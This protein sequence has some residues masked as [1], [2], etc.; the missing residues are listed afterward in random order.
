MTTKKI[1]SALVAV[2]IAAMMPLSVFANYDPVTDTYSNGF[3]GAIDDWINKEEAGLTSW[4]AGRDYNSVYKSLRYANVFNTDGSGKYYYG[5]SG[6][7]SSGATY[8]FLYGGGDT[9]NTTTNS[10]TTYKVL[11]TTNNSWYNPITNNYQTINNIQYSPTYNTYHITNNEYNTY[12]TNNITYVSYYIVDPVEELSWYYEIYYMLPDG[13]NTYNLQPEDVWGQYFIYDATNYREVAE[14]DGTT[15]ALLHFDGNLQDSS[16]HN[17]NVSYSTGANYNFAQ[18]DFTGAL[19]WNDGLEHQLNITLPEN[20]DGD[21]T[22]EGRVNVL[23]PGEKVLQQCKDGIWVDAPLFRIT[24]RSF[25]D[26]EAMKSYIA[27]TYSELFDIN[28]LE[29]IKGTWYVWINSADFL[30]PLRICSLPIVS[31]GAV[32]L[33]FTSEYSLFSGNVTTLDNEPFQASTNNNNGSYTVL[34]TR[35]VD[36]NNFTKYFPPTKTISEFKVSGAYTFAVV[37]KDN[38]LHYYI[39]GLEVYTDESTGDLGNVISLNGRS[40]TVAMFD[41]LRV[42]NK[43][44]YTDTYTPSAQPFD[45][46][47]VLVVPET[48]SE[49]QLAIKSNV[50]VAN[51]RVGGVRPTYPSNGDVYVY[52]ENDVVRDVQ[53]YQVDGWYSVTATIY[54]NGAWTPFNGKDLSAYVDTEPSPGGGSGGGTDPTP[55]PG[56]GGDS[57]GDGDGGD[58]DEGGVLDLLEKLFGGLI[59]A[60]TALIGGAVSLLTGVLGGL[61]DLLTTLLSFVTGFTDFLTASFAFLPAD[62]LAALSAGIIL[63]VVIAVVKF[64][65]GFL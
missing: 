47:L 15:L 31:V 64:I 7:K 36:V 52:L 23:Q 65:G 22:V 13:R 44:L 37:R 30:Y 29:W 43:A 6:A 45:T 9:Y 38:V 55:S 49:T 24:G 12:I 57:G 59:D 39:N 18:S 42:S 16:S 3:I 61:V 51:L 33:V 34:N 58:E 2:A 20:L 53:Q 63:M 54:E 1:L 28:T 40:D 60:I 56:P 48:G 41:E 62:M 46:N 8:D 11:N 14:D 19:Y 10:Y 5:N 27:D 26:L 32:S 50:P 21:F 4:F 35:T 25:N 17:C